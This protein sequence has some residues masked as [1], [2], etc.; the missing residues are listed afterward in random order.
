MNKTPA[1][2]DSTQPGT[3]AAIFL[4]AAFALGQA[5]EVNDGNLH[6]LGLMWIG[7]AI[8]ALLAG[9]RARQWAL[10]TRVPLMAIVA[11]LLC[12]EWVQLLLWGLGWRRQ[13]EAPIHLFVIPM[14]VAGIGA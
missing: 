14:I 9:V 11:S 6:P 4:L 12:V 3:Q 1:L 7:V 13:L 2:S 8:L 5:V 10:T